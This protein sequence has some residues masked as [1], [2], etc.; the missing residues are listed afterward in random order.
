MR[1]WYLSHRRPEK[2]QASL[3]NRAVSTE[4]SL[5]DEKCDNL[6]SCLIYSHIKQTIMLWMFFSNDLLS[7]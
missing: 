3:Y 4:P 5:C 7:R 1:L 2:A 6:M